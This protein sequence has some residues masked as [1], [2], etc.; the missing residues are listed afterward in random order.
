MRLTFRIATALTALLA[1]TSPAAAQQIADRAAPATARFRAEGHCYRRLGDGGRSGGSG[2]R[3]VVMEEGAADHDPVPPRAG[4]ARH[5]RV[6][7]DEG[8][9][10]RVHR[11]QARLRRGVHLAGPEPVPP[12]HRGAEHGER[13]QRQSAGGHRVRLQ[14]LDGEPEP[15]RAARAWHPRRAHQLPLVPAPQRDV[16]QGRLHPDRP[17]ADRLR[18]AEGADGDRDGARRAHGN[19]LRRRAL[20]PQRQ[21]QRDLQPVRR[22]LHHGRVHHGDRRR[23]LPQSGRRDRDGRRDRRRNPRNRAHARPA[24]ADLHRQARLRSA[25]ERTISGSA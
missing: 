1:I 5:Q 12:Q 16:G 7:D 13:R 11:L 3:R 10:R 24:R 20:P 9:G 8:S 19:Q 17:V 14:Q 21:R 18:A 15:A 25:G 23:G 4:Q 6:R 2:G 22:Q